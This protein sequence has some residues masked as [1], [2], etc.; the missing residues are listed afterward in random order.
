MVLKSAPEMVPKLSQ[1]IPKM[2]LKCSRN[3]PNLFPKLSQCIPKMVLKCSRNG[4]NV[5]PSLR[6][7]RQTQQP[8]NRETG[9][10]INSRIET[11]KLDMKG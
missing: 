7:Q 10:E 4:P 9:L 6:S 2:V 3:G 11:F 8:T 5:F 1:C